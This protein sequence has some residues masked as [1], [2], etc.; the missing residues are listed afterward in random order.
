MAPR[1]STKPRKLCIFPLAHFVLAGFVIL[2][3]G[4][5]T[6]RTEAGIPSIYG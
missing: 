4:L 1:S 6:R 5:D 3:R 2:T